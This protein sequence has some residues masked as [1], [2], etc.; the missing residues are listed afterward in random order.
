[1]FTRCRV[2]CCLLTVGLL[3]YFGV[4]LFGQTQVA[5]LRPSQDLHW[6]RV[7]PTADKP[8]GPVLYQLLFSGTGTPGTVPVFDSNPRH[9]TNSSITVSGNNI[10]I[11]GTAS[12]A[13]L[14]LSTGAASG[15]VLMS[16]ASGNGTWQ[17]PASGTV[18]SVATGAGLIGGPITTTGTIS[19]PDGG[20]TNNML[21]ANSRSFVSKT[22]TGATTIIG[23]TC[24]NYLGGTI[25]VTA[26]PGVA[27]N[28]LVRADAQFNASHFTGTD[29]YWQIFI[30]TTA[31][32]C[33]T[34]STGTMQTQ[35]PAAL[36][37]SQYYLTMSV[38]GV[39]PVAAGSTTTF[40]LNGRAFSGT[41]IYFYY[42]AMD[43]I[44]VP[45]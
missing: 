35:V 43:A 22:T 24:T 42:G 26:P 2:Q 14:K 36:P 1:M 11:A 10:S 27:G 21:N 13:G 20:V 16:D 32:S 37:S 18:T 44:F 45:Q 30:G 39:F 17:T 15:K 8:D 38:S 4:S 12:M 7:S 28:V 6:Q 34:S 41:G 3:S 31:T 23:N 9:L 25:T 5:S 19:I 40:F 33:S 29:D